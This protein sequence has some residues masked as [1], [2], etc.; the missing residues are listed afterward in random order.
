MFCLS[1]LIKFRK[2]AWKELCL[3]REKFRDILTEIQI[4][5]NI[6]EAIGNLLHA[7]I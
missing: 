3:D 1:F 2:K 6:S 4:L 5:S 7:C